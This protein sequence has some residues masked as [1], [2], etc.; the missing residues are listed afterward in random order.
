VGKRLAV[1]QSSYIPWKG[2]FD[3]ISSA[4][5]FVLFDDAQ[6]T[7]R[8]WRNRNRI[9]TRDGCLWLTIPVS[10]KGNY[11]APIKDIEISDPHWAERHW[12]TIQAAYCRAPHF[13]TYEEAFGRLYLGHQERRLSQVN[14]SL[15]EGVCGVLG[16]T[17]KL[18]WSMD[19]RLADGKTERLVKLCLDTG[20]DV[21]ISG[22]TARSYIDAGLFAR[23]GVELV[24]FDYSG[25]R[26]YEQ[27]YPPFDHFVSI[28]DLIFHVGPDARRYLLTP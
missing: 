25:Y 5:E 17:T 4:D 15:I 18:S 3:L 12:K 23:A 8:D 14:R 9:K 1:V 16:I 7:R 24:F 2:Y 21:Y 22:P 6:Y 26:E 13:S 27:L 10:A 20:S 19:Y 28:V 11:L